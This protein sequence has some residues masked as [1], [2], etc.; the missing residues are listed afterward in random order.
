MYPLIRTDCFSLH[1]SKY[2]WYLLFRKTGILVFVMVSEVQNEVDTQLSES[3]PNLVSGSVEEKKYRTKILQ[4]IFRFLLILD[5]VLK[6]R[7]VSVNIA[8]RMHFCQIFLI[9]GVK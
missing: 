2:N 5:S 3:T 1:G 4:T 7:Q 8:W 9:M 6:T